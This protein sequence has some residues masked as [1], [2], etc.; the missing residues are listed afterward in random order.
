MGIARVLALEPEVLVC[1]EITSALDVSVQATI[2]DLVRG[3]RDRPRVAILFISHDLAVVSQ[4]SDRI[5]VMRD[6][7]IVEEGR[8][9]QVI[10]KPREAYLRELLAP[11]PRFISGRARLTTDKAIDLPAR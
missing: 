11:V 10:T 6:G 2:L 8:A 1:D 7:R 9:E 5:V 3:L 4:I